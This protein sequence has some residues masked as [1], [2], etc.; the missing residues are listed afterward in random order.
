MSTAVVGSARKM[1]LWE[2]RADPVVT[3][4]QMPK[5]PRAVPAGCVHLSIAPDPRQPPGGRRGEGRGRGSDCAESFLLRWF[6]TLLTQRLC[7]A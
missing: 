5:A 7:P 6:R 2:P 3:P 4:L 1:A